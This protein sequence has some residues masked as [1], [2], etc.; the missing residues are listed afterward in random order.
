MQQTTLSNSVRPVV[1]PLHSGTWKQWKIVTIVDHPKIVCLAVIFISL[2]MWQRPV[3]ASTDI[4]ADKLAEFFV[5]K[6]EGVRAAATAVSSPWRSVQCSAL[7]LPW[8]FHWVQDCVDG[9]W[10]QWSV[11]SLLSSRVHTKPKTVRL[12]I[13]PGYDPLI[14]GTWSS[15]ALELCA[16]VRGAF[17]CQRQLY[18]TRTLT[19]VMDSTVQSRSESWHFD[20]AYS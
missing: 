1:C 13:A 6:V 3:S 17:V 4:N 16:L 14:V 8:G 19:P 15:R 2:V 5:V 7:Q 12:P 10:L 11:S 18:G 20:C 9:I